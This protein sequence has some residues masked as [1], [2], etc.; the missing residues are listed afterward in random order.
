[1]RSVALDLA[2]RAGELDDLRR[3]HAEHYLALAEQAAPELERAVT[4]LGLKG[5]KLLAPTVPVL[6]NDRSLAIREAIHDVS[7]T[8]LLTIAEAWL[9]LSQ[10]DELHDDLADALLGL[11]A[12]AGHHHP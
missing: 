12:A 6:I 8:M 2:S 11:I 7:L 4:H 5:L 3:Q 1:M 10:F 9:D